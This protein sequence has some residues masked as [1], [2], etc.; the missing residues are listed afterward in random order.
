MGDLKCSGEDIIKLIYEITCEMNKKCDDAEFLMAGIEKRQS[1]MD[2]Y[3]IYKQLHPE[4][5]REKLKE[6]VKEIIIMDKKISASLE[7]HRKDVKEKLT[8]SKNKNKVLGYFT[9]TVVSGRVMDFKQ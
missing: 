7:A 9:S 4:N 1:L 6:M 3:D 2:E 8:E 5:N